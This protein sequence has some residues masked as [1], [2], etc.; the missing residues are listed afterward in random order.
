[1]VDVFQFLPPKVDC[2]IAANHVERLLKQGLSRLGLQDAEYDDICEATVL[3][4]TCVQQVRR[5]V[6]AVTSDFKEFPEQLIRH[7]QM[8]TY[9]AN[10]KECFADKKVLLL[11]G[12]LQHGKN[13]VTRGRALSPGL[14]SEKVVDSNGF[15]VSSVLSKVLPQLGG[16]LL[17]SALVEAGTWYKLHSMGHRQ[18]VHHQEVIARIEQQ[19]RGLHEFRQELLGSMEK[20]L[21]HGE[22][23][24]G[25]LERLFLKDKVDTH[26]AVRRTIF[27]KLQLGEALS[28][29]ILDQLQLSTNA[30]VVKAEERICQDCPIC[31]VADILQVIESSYAMELN[32][33]YQGMWDADSSDNNLL[34]REKQMRCSLLPLLQ[35]VHWN[36]ASPADIEHAVC[37][38][39][40]GVGSIVMD[41]DDYRNADFDSD[42]QEEVT[43]PIS[44]ANAPL[45]MQIYPSWSNWMP[46]C[47]RRCTSSA[48]PQVP[49][50][51]Q[52]PVRDH[53]KGHGSVTV[54][55]IDVGFNDS[56]GSGE[57]TKRS[58]VCVRDQQGAIQVYD[59]ERDLCIAEFDYTH[60]TAVAVDAVS[61]SLAVVRNLGYCPCRIFP[62]GVE[63][64]HVPE[65]DNW[66]VEVWDL[67]GQDRIQKYNS[68]KRPDAFAALTL[69][70]KEPGLAFASSCGQIDVILASG[71]EY[72]TL[73]A[74]DE[75]QVLSMVL[76]AE[77]LVIGTSKGIC[78]VW[79][80][81]GALKC[82]KHVCCKSPVQHVGVEVLAAGRCLL[83]A[84]TEFG[85][86]IWR[87]RWSPGGKFEVC[88]RWEPVPG[89]RLCKLAVASDRDSPFPLTFF[90]FGHGPS[91][92]F[93]LQSKLIEDCCMWIFSEPDALAAGT[94]SSSL[95]ALLGRAFREAVQ[96]ASV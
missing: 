83:A 44:K 12:F 90:A 25:S 58:L 49:A 95:G 14:L 57:S 56:G 13:L 23:L 6:C 29:H 42:A 17:G 31:E 73:L 74:H 30:L 10:L 81:Q 33:R 24:R 36:C 8:K 7:H 39:T 55:G 78:S 59:T 85:A 60:V 67:S 50:R 79:T 40:V 34:Q 16:T 75:G 61:M 48:A 45:A 28:E 2:R 35:A 26:L 64:V 19:E 4:S 68:G 77:L 70:S 86:A 69:N 47:Q 82:L 88:G 93:Q 9:Q 72:R 66:G 15:S 3:D 54:L 5:L 65:C 87:S 46:R 76:S 27:E 84:V 37:L 52:N 71:T 51:L 80:C 62:D 1:M 38:S 21:Q 41:L 20:L 53:R 94:D 43:M 11:Q 89:L 92:S 18:G 91:E 96:D 63:G 22:Q 32:M